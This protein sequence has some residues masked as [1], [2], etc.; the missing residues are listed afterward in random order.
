MSLTW[1]VPYLSPPGPPQVWR[2]GVTLEQTGRPLRERNWTGNSLAWPKVAKAFCW[3]PPCVSIQKWYREVQG[4]L[5]SVLPFWVAKHTS[6]FQSSSTLFSL[7]LMFSLCLT[8][9]LPLHL[10]CALDL[11]GGGRREFSLASV[12][13]PTLSES[14]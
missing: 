1:A 12:A 8:F 3:I 5:D 2:V 9:P 10:C 6:V 11:G 13:V 4:V 14:T 7:H